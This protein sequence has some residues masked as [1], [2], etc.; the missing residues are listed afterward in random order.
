LPCPLNFVKAKLELEKLEIGSILEVL[1]DEGEPVR[2]APADF[3]EQGQ[4]V[5]EVKNTGNCYCV[6]VKV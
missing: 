4:D 3:D 1:P 6:W 5:V 2:N